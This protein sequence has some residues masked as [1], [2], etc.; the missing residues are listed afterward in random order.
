MSAA[1]PPVS[2]GGGGAP[3][4]A[5]RLPVSVTAKRGLLTR[6]GGDKPAAG[7]WRLARAVAAGARGR[8]GGAAPTVFTAG[9]V[10]VAGAREDPL[11]G[12]VVAAPRACAAAGTP[13]AP[14]L[15]PFA[16]G[17]PLTCRGAA[18]DG[19]T[20]A[21]EGRASGRGG[22]GGSTGP[23]GSGVRLLRAARASRSRH[24]CSRRS[25]RCCS[26][27]RSR[28]CFRRRAAANAASRA[29]NQGAMVGSTLPKSWPHRV[30]ARWA[31]AGYSGNAGWHRAAAA[32][33]G[34]SRFAGGCG[35]ALP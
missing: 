31:M 14:L 32:L 9:P 20:S 11:R 15:P 10:A 22:A 16:A 28:C 23:G 24:C 18:A 30:S 33:R 34:V 21:G 6:E 8:L 12:T 19:V 26:K 17:W 3:E 2:E 13:L 5:A 7:G 27:A 1:R 29:A 35:N 25:R 4:T